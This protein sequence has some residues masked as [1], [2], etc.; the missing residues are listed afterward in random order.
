[1][2]KYIIILAASTMVAAS[3]LFTGCETPEKKVENA[4]DKVQDA[5]R[6]L[7]EVQKDAEAQKMADS[8][9]FRVFKTESEVKIRDNEIFIDDLR[10]KMTKS[11]RK[12]DAMYEKTI[13]D[14]EQKN[15]DM[16]A[17]IDSYGKN[18]GDWESFKREYN[19]DMD[20]LGVALKNLTV[21]NKK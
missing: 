8:D 12:L 9:A 20:E 15:R 11:G 5:K 6:D 1:M 18:Q 2:K 7:K 13:A 14:L 4:Q 17:R 3:A 16:R 10:T 21:D 19:R